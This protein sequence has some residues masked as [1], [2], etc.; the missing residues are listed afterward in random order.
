MRFI[1]CVN[2]RYV[3]HEAIRSSRGYRTTR[4]AGPQRRAAG[5]ADLP[6]LTPKPASQAVAPVADLIQADPPT[7]SY[8]ER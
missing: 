6:L 5:A 3:Q 2:C 8:A 1:F 7:V 4:P